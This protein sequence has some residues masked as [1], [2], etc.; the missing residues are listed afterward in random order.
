MLVFR[1]LVLLLFCF[2]GIHLQGQ[3]FD[4]NDHCNDAY[5]HI[6]KLKLKEGKNLLRLEQSVRPK[7]LIVNFL[8]SYVDFLE[9]Y[10]SGSVHLYEHKKK[11]LEKRIA[12]LKTG[13]K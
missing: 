9:V 11:G 4:F 7:N 8:L 1:I 10:T 2:L 12:Q 6:I 5:Q 3:I 13:D